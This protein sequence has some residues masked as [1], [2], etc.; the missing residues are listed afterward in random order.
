MPARNAHHQS[1]RAARHAN[2]RHP[3]KRH[4]RQTEDYLIYGFHPVV[5]A[6]ANPAR[7]ITKLIATEN[8]LR[9][10]KDAGAQ[11]PPTIEHARPDGLSKLV[12]SEA[13]HQG[14]VLEVAPL[15][16]RAIEDF[17]DAQL[18]ICL[19]QVSDPHNV[20]AILRSAA[21]FGADGVVTTTRHAPHETGVLAKA[22]SGAL[23]LIP[24]AAVPNLAR[25]LDQ[26]GTYGFARVGLD[27]RAEAKIDTAMDGAR[28]ALV[29]GAEGQGLRRLTRERCDRL[30]QLPTQGPLAS[31][32]VS[33]AAALALYEARRHLD[34][35]ASS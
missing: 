33:N 8:G 16:D 31:L 34:G 35:N 1:R 23:D 14:L 19:D 10:L 27:E 2:T 6:L 30:A 20:G 21:A 7:R 17:A 5:A 18:L 26:L 11:L 22:A 28:I 32:N 24:T 13:V 25:A 4:G 12:G 15:P 29:L 9:R 3:A